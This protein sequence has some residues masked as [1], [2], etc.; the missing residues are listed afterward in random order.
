MFP[1][2]TRRNDAFRHRDFALYFL[3][4]KWKNQI[5]KFDWLI[6][7]FWPLPTPS[8]KLAGEK[9]PW[10]DNWRDLYKNKVY[11]LVF[12]DEI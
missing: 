4:D 12:R 11:K 1:E 6:D 10:P 5:H 9:Y 2:Y 8:T 3:H 7:R